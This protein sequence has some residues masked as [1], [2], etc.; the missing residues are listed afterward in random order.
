VSRIAIFAPVFISLK[1][2]FI[3]PERK[4][5]PFRIRL[6]KFITGEK[7]ANHKKE[8]YFRTFVSVADGF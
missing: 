8:S 3:D 7:H 2:L 4:I 5:F 1:A 6:I